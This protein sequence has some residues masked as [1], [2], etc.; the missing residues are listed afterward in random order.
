MTKRLT[1]A[2]MFIALGVIGSM[3]KLFGSIALDSLSAFVGTV[4]LGPGFGFLLGS[5]GHLATA[6][7]S[8]F[9]LSLPVHLVT[10]VL[11]G[12]CMVCY[13]FVRAKTSQKWGMN[14]WLS[15]VVA[16]LINTPLALLVLYP[17]LGPLVFTLIIPLSMG[18]LLNLVLAE[19]VLYFFET[20][21]SNL[22]KRK[23]AEE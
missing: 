5:F 18:A 16:Y 9:P 22:Q 20:T 6:V 23:Q 8:G 3:I 15:I 14:R 10:A 17:L 12:I 19:V 13:G 1:L 7:F 11:M 21:S 4:F 2:A